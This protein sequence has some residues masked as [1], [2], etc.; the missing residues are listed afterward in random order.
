M[1]A[2]M[3]AVTRAEGTLALVFSVT[4][5]GHA[6]AQQPQPKKAPVTVGERKAPAAEKQAPSQPAP[7]QPAPEAAAPPADA[8]A[9]TDTPPQDADPTPAEQPSPGDAQPTSGEKSQGAEGAAA[10]GGTAA[11]AGTAPAPAAP[12]PAQQQGSG[13]PPVEFKGSESKDKAPAAQKDAKAKEAVPPPPAPKHIAP[14]TAIVAGARLGWFFPTGALWHK[15]FDQGDQV[16]QRNAVDWSGYA[17]SGPMFELN[18]GVRLGRSY[19]VFA[20]WEHAFLGG[21]SINDDPTLGNPGSGS[22]DMFGAGLRFSTNPDEFGL[23]L[24]IGLGYRVFSTSWS[25]G[26]K[27]DFEGESISAR[28]GVG[29]NYRFSE[30]FVISPMLTVGSGSFGS[31]RITYPDGSTRSAM[32]VGDLDVPAQH[33]PVGIVVGGHFDFPILDEKD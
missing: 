6:A 15:A 1:F 21:G 26:T 7:A 29:I 30:T 22:T 11:A 17:S 3:R 4:L 20:T 13:P 5:C 25:S 9:S 18:A 14:N 23:L 27:I 8:P 28:L 10:V 19:T 32:S 24:E 16:I 2:P 12:A 33:V 31:G